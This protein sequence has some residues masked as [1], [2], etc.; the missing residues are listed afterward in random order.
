ME[1]YNLNILGISEVKKKGAEEVK[2]HKGHQ[3][4]YSGVDIKT[5][6]VGN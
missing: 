5:R 6:T 3:M 1:K 2:L 4:R